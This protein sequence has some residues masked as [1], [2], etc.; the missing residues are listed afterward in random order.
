MI[1]YCYKLYLLMYYYYNSFISYLTN[2]VNNIYKIDLDKSNS[3]LIK[4]K[5]PIWY[6]AFL[7]IL[8]KYLNI[9]IFYMFYM[10]Y[11][12][13][14]LYI[15]NISLNDRKYN[16]ILNGYN[17]IASI[18]KF[19]NYK[20]YCSDKINKGSLTIKLSAVHGNDINEYDIINYYIDN[21][22]NTLQYI[23]LDINANNNIFYIPDNI[24]LFDILNDK[25]ITRKLSIN[26]LELKITDLVNIILNK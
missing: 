14:G 23:I 19:F 11:P 15:M 12:F 8:Y 26:D 1:S 5:Y 10:F 22:Y 20:K 16:I 25:Y 18:N 4:I 2:D 13:N 9:N 21:E 17:N 3:K 7:N 24:V 6:Y